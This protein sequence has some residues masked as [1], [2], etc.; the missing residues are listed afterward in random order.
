MPVLLSLRC[1][2]SVCFLPLPPP[3]KPVCSASRRTAVAV[4]LNLL[5][6]LQSLLVVLRNLRAVILAV[7]SVVCSTT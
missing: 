1:W 3:L 2:L 5:V 4:P 7:T 6:V